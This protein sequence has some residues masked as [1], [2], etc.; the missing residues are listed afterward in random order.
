MT[1]RRAGVVYIDTNPIVYAL[2]APEDLASAL[3]ALF[4][5]FKQRPGSAVTSELT[6]AEVLVKRRV[7]DRDYLEL[8]V[9]SDIFDL[10]PISRDV[11]YDTADYRRAAGV[12]LA[13]G[14]I[15]MPKLPDSIHVVTA[16]KAGCR[17][18]LSSD[19]GIKLP[20]EMRLV[21]ADVAGIVN[22]TRELT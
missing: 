12:K 19:V 5:L 7:P 9:W 4:A 20:D 21:R 8:L 14:R 3:K 6:L 18:F 13:D 16:V 22:L 2:E 1:D 11:L 17:V 10:R 15:K